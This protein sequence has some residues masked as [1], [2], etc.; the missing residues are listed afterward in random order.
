MIYGAIL[1]GGVGKR[2]ENY[3][4]P[5]QFITVAG[6]PIIILT[7]REFLKNDRFDKIYIAV[8]ADWMD[9]LKDLMDRYFSAAEQSRVELVKGGSERLDSFINVLDA[10]LDVRQGFIF[11]LKNLLDFIT[12]FRFI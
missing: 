12:T 5:K 6:T 11:F 2:V 9:Y 8:H 10:I 7:L 4:I 1:A 3:S